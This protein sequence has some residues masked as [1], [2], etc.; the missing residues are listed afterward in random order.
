MKKSVGLAAALLAMLALMILL[1][2]ALAS[3]DGSRLSR[4]AS[5]F[6]PEQLNQL[7]GVELQASK[8]PEKNRVNFTLKNNTGGTVYYGEEIFLESMIDG[9]WCKV[10]PSGEISFLSVLNSLPAGEETGNSV[11]LNVWIPVS[12]GEYR[13]IKE[14]SL[15]ENLENIYPVSAEF[16]IR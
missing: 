5:G 14:I 3:R 6:A 11:S 8:D 15:K 4:P 12:A 13:V 16:T 1:M 2:N 10:L 9:E 7:E